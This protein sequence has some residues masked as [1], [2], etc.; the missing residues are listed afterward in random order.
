MSSYWKTNGYDTIVY[1]IRNNDV[2]EV[3]PGV[4]LSNFDFDELHFLILIDR[5]EVNQDGTIPWNPGYLPSE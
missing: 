5:E 3:P 4:F 1:I 2:L